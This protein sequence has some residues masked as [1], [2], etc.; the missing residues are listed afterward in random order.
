M[1]RGVIELRRGRLAAKGPDR[2]EKEDFSCTFRPSFR[3]P[4]RSS[5]RPPSLPNLRGEATRG[6]ASGDTAGGG[7][8][9]SNQ[10][11]ESNDGCQREIPR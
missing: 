7:L 2:E 10:R 11:E 8:E 5:K 4:R 6:E 3:G 9:R 1:S